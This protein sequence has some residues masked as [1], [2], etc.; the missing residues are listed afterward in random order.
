[1]ST[2]RTLALVKPDAFAAGHSGKIVDK[3]LAADLQLVAVKTLHLTLAQAEGFYHVHKERPFF[4]DLCKF[5]SEG[6]ILAMVLS[7]EDAIKRWRDLMGPTNASD[8]PAGTIRGDFGTSIERNA[9]HGSDA[10]DTAAFET[11][12]FFSGIELV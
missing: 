10:P 4:G 9:S 11:G 7:G 3:I 5:M 2:Q 8:A 1:M 12:Y 6:K